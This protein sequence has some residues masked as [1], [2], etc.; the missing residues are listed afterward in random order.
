M[1]M[2]AL[3]STEQIGIKVKKNLRCVDF[4]VQSSALIKALSTAQWG[5]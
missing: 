5:G 2:G 1:A 4:H 3:N